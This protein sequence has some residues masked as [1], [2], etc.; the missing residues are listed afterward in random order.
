P[1]NDMSRRYSQITIFNVVVNLWFILFFFLALT[2]L[3][4]SSTFFDSWNW[5]VFVYQVHYIFI[6]NVIA[7]L[8]TFLIVLPMYFK[9]GIQFDVTIWKNMIRYAIPVLIA[10]IAYTINEGFDKILL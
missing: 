7:S 8:V 4:F 2:Q 1:N 6:A 5:I 10:G 3:L 9:I